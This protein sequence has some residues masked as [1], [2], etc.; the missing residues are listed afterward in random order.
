MGQVAQ[1]LSAVRQ[2]ID[3]A[4][5]KA[6]RDPGEVRL[7]AVSKTHPPDLLREAYE[8]GHRL[9]GENKV[10]EAVAKA[11][12]LTD[13]DELRWAFVGHLQTNKARDVAAFAAEFHALDSFRV[14]RALD[15]RLQELGHGLDVYLQVNS[16]GEESKFGLAPREMVSFASTLRECSALRVRGLM[17][18][19]ANSDDERV[20]RSSFET[21]RKLQERLRGSDT[22]AGSYDELSMGMSGDFE[23]AIEY[24]ATTVR[25]GQA[26]FGARPAP[27]DA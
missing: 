6:G 4:C 8:A 7:M 12:A 18:L 17:T 2:R 14:A 19:A 9:Y 5:A 11:G 22:A 23:L 20:V 25:V 16:S 1:R 10:Q 3:T 21:M 27:V 24:G 13:L 15:R 26:V